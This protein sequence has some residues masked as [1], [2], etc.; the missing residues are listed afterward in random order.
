MMQSINF[1]NDFRVF[2]LLI[3]LFLISC[4]RPVTQLRKIP[5]M[6]DLS[7]GAHGVGYRTLFV[8]DRTRPAVPYSDW[9][10]KIYPDHNA[11]LGRQFQINVWYPASAETGESMQFDQYVQLMGRETDFEFSEEQERFAKDR[12]IQQTNGLGGNGHFTDKELQLLLEMEVLAQYEAE[13]LKVPFP[14]VV[15]PSGSSAAYHSITAEFLASHGFV[16]VGFSPKG[17]F[18]WGMENSTIGLETAVYDLEFVVQKIGLLPFVNLREITLAGNAISASVCALAVARNS[19]YKGLVSLEGGLPSA[20]EQRLLDGTEIYEPQ[21]IQVPTLFIYAPHPAIHPSHTFH[22]IHADRYY[23]H[24]PNMSEFAMLNYG[25]FDA[26]VPDI[27]GEHEGGTKDGF[28]VANELLFRFLKKVHF[29]SVGMLFDDQFV[30]KNGAQIDTTFLH[31]AIPAAPNMAELKALF[32]KEGIE[33]IDSIYQNLEGKGNSTPFYPSFYRGYRNWLAW[34]KDPEFNNRLRLYQ[35]A[36]RSFPESTEVNYYLAS[37]L[38]RTGDTKKA[39]WQYERTLELLETDQD[40]LLDAT[41]KR[42]IRENTQEALDD[43]KPI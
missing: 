26:F 6:G 7:L 19:Q 9:D 43:L 29:D 27:I 30:T 31:K 32:L 24:F 20:F 23:A 22:L 37:Y 17:R 34:K 16:V 1:L 12:F 10:G 42:Q 21:N 25:M 4:D 5:M 35:M 28:E 36:Y 39:L 41:R 33:A 40:T 38:A 18:S 15:F 3:A 13:P 14:V 8:Y 2:T 11:A